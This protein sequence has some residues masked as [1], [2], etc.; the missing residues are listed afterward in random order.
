MAD[1]TAR[2]KIDCKKDFGVN[3]SK[4][5]LAVKILKFAEGSFGWS[6]ETVKRVFEKFG[7]AFEL[8]LEVPQTRMMPNSFYG[9]DLTNSA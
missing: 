8:S 6:T 1:K 7:I 3:H 5:D 4:F 9:T 2:E